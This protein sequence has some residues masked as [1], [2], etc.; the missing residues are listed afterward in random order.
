MKIGTFIPN[1]AARE[2][3]NPSAILI[4]SS[5]LLYE[6]AQHHLKA[7]NNAHEGQAIPGHNLLSRT[8][9]ELDEQINSLKRERNDLK[10]TLKTL[11]EGQMLFADPTPQKSH[12]RETQLPQL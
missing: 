5:I 4:I 10:D 3:R 8:L 7:W 9:K 11:K 12:Q 2:S 6:A 1:T